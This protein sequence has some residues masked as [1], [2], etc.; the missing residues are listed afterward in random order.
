[1]Y[2]LKEIKKTC[3]LFIRAYHSYNDFMLD[4]V[5]SKAPIRKTVNAIFS[6]ANGIDMP[7]EFWITQASLY[8]D[9][10]MLT[11]P[12]TIKKMRRAVEP[13][14]SEDERQALSFWADNPGFW[15]FY[16]IEEILG[17]DF[18]IIEDLVTGDTHLMHSLDITYM[19]TD[20]VSRN[21]HYLSLMLPNGSC[22]QALGL[23]K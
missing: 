6:K 12:K 22:L 15:C 7:N 14:A 21:K 17:D 1:M 5:E 9:A 3:D 11:E 8:T 23:P 10:Q 18:F 19:Q 16:A 4:W 2:N 13:F 20:T